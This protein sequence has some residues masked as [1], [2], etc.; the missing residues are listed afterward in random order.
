MKRVLTILASIVAALLLLRT[1]AGWVFLAQWVPTQGKARLEAELERRFPIDVSIG[2]LRCEP[3]RGFLL[4]DAPVA[5][6]ASQEGWFAAP[7]MRL[8][9]GWWPLLLQRTLVFRAEGPTTSPAATDLTLSGR[10][11]LTAA[12]LS[13]DVRT[14]AVSLTSL[15]PAFRRRLPRALSDGAFQANL[16]VSHQAGVPAII[17]GT[18]KGS[19][20]VWTSPTFRARTDVTVDGRVTPPDQRGGRWGIDGLVTLRDGTLDGIAL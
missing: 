16:R 2:A 11:D 4:T 18:V 8:Q 7:A 17:T 15:S 20:V 13:L 10:Y 6:R 1:I 5:D 3:L 14:A 19:R 9:I 12:S